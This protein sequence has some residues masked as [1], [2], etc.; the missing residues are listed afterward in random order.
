MS[1]D[2]GLG[3]HEL[4][5]R[6]GDTVALDGLS[7]RAQ[8]GVMH[9]FVGTN[10]AGKTT[11]MRIAIG[12]LAADSGSVLWNGEPITEEQRQ[13]IGYMPEERG[14]YPKMRVGDQLRYFAELHGVEARAAAD[15][16]DHWL[17][18]LEVKGRANDRVEALSLGNQQRVQL[19]ASL[20]FEPDVLILDEPFSGLDP[21][22]VD[23]LS[24]V[25][26]EYCYDRQVP[27][28]FSSHQ[29]ELVERLCDEVTIIKDGR[30]LATGGVSELRDQR[31]GS[32]WRLEIEGGRVLDPA[33][34]G[35]EMLEAGL[36]RLSDDYDPQRLLAH[37]QAVGRVI[38]FG[39][40][41][42]SLAD[43]FREAVDDQL[44][45]DDETVLE[46]AR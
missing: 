5:K 14:L 27:V 19:A 17:R 39:E 29:L 43:L 3:L 6:Y 13:R 31:G 2:Q 41:Q 32:I 36:Y 40:V 7:L 44:D 37:G 22:G 34:S 30:L 11:A 38:G 12:V 35:I 9:G 20:V 4:H 26:T 21:I 16:T 10:G 33:P 46:V 42:A 1:D 28:V 8:P 24:G 23:V 18:R 15:R 25:L 45:Q